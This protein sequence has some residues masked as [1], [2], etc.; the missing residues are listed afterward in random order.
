L[1]SQVRSTMPHLF[2][3]GSPLVEHPAARAVVDF[4]PRRELEHVEYFMLCVSAHYLTCATPVPT[5]VDNQVRQKLWRDG[6]SK[7]EALRMASFVLA[8]RTWDF[9]ALSSRT[10]FGA[11][12][13]AWERTPLSGH[14][15]E[16]YT[17]AAGAYAG[18]ARYDSPDT[19]A[20]RASLLEGIAEETTR[21]SEI[22]GSVWRANDGMGALLASVSIAHNFGDLDRVIDM[23]ELPWS[24][25]LRLRFYKLGTKPFDPEGR[26]RYEGRLWSAG[27]LYKSAIAGSSMALENHRHFALRKP[28]V[29]RT[30]PEFRVPIA[31]FF[32]GWGREIAQNA[33]QEQRLEVG[34]ALIEAWPRQ[35]K[36]AA[37]GRGLMPLLAVDRALA[38]EAAPL[39]RDARQ[40][41]ILE[42]TQ[43][44]FEDEWARGALHELE[45]I[46]ARAR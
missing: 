13:S 1:V 23:W 34:R 44:E 28:R 32:D 29:L 6:V 19:T 5:D 41:R 3:P 33:T 15:G 35:P 43:E 11:A 14:Y 25:P 2:E 45:E 31:P 8:S 30:R 46:P 12:G 20:M 18:L 22:F 16:W 10:S 40:R 17:V 9:S 4:D 37:Y 21:H 42:T 26:L 24:D 7:D 39:L 36:T 38:K 27:E